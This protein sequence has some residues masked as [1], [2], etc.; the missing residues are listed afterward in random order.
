MN[1]PTQTPNGDASLTALVTGIMNDGQ[2]LLHQQLTLFKS[3]I[4][5]ELTK[6]REAAQS[7]TLGLGITAV[8]IGLL[9]FMLAH[10][11]S[12]GFAVP[13]WAGFGVVGGALVIV[14]LIVYAAGRNKLEE[15]HPLPEQ[16][17]QGI[18]ENV[19]WLKTP[20]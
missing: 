17:V 14:G 20:K 9:C 2:E 10:L 7:L 6:A 4:R 12:W 16:T 11:V 8:G 1:T 3:E 15:V 13:T 18:K 5:Q 19:Q